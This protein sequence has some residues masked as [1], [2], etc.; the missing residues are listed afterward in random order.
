MARIQAQKKKLLAI[1]ESFAATPGQGRS[2]TGAFDTTAYPQENC[3]KKDLTEYAENL[4]GVTLKYPGLLEG[5]VWAIEPTFYATFSGESV[6]A[7]RVGIKKVRK[8]WYER[9]FVHFRYLPTPVTEAE[10]IQENIDAVYRAFLD[11]R[12]SEAIVGHFRTDR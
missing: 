12:K 6:A 9:E 4:Y 8:K 11:A 2:G 5:Y 10:D 3:A 7:I 1:A